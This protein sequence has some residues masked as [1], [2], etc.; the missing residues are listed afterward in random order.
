VRND[1]LIAESYSGLFYLNQDTIWVNYKLKEPIL[2]FKIAF[3]DSDYIFYNDDC[4]EYGGALYIYNKKT[5]ETK[6]I[7][8]TSSSTISS[9][10]K[11]K[12]GYV[13][14]PSLKLGFGF[15]PSLKIPIESLESQDIQDVIIDYESTGRQ[16]Y[17]GPDILKIPKQNRLSLIKFP[18][19]YQSIEES[20][21]I[22]SKYSNSVGV[23][24]DDGILNNW[25]G[26]ND[27]VSRFKSAKENGFTIVKGDTLIKVS[28]NTTPSY[29]ENY[30]IN[31]N[32]SKHEFVLLDK[33]NTPV[34]I[35]IKS[36]NV[37]TYNWEENHLINRK[38]IYDVNTNYR[39]EWT[40]TDSTTSFVI[41]YHDNKFNIRI[42]SKNTVL[43]YCL[44]HENLFLYFETLGG[45][46]N[47]YGLI[48]IT[49]TEEF[50]KLYGEK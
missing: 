44:L 17:L 33:N 27:T 8:T 11:T 40:K 20:I 49:D 26:N 48:E 36:K 45:V 41:K 7:V 3:E 23:Y 21:F 34:I 2:L 47:K 50:L 29:D 25:L 16:W 1:T 39:I 42:D 15:Y 19:K 30:R 5:K 24:D 31:E 43:Q 35:D 32:K 14:S 4:G 9:V 38:L 10:V 12:C 13:Y 37:F 18:S 46:N 22:T 6:I 28:F